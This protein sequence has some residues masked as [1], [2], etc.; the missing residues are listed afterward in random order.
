MSTSKLLCTVGV[1]VIALVVF[2]GG[3]VASASVP[4]HFGG[5]AYGVGT[6]LEARLELGTTMVLED[7]FGLHAITCTGSTIK[8]N[9]ERVTPEGQ[10]K[11]KVSTLDFAPCPEKHDVT[12]QANGELEI[13][14]IVGTTNGT[15]FSSGMKFKFFNTLMNQTCT[16]NSGGGTDIGTLTGATA[17][18]SQAT[19]D[20]NGLLPLEGCSASSLRW[21]A[22]YTMIPLGF[23]MEA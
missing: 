22:K 3:G 23:V 8:W 20:V 21:T 6:P 15:V 12:V 2:L 16:A 17:S 18:T 9:L 14:N 4:K 7:A 5:S 19:I 1:L 11:G 10:P 13:R